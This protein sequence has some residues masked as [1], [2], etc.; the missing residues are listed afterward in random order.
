M[1]SDWLT[2]LVYAVIALGL[3]KGAIILARLLS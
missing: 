3:L 1:R 2:V